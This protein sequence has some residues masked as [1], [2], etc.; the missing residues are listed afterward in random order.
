MK[1]YLHIIALLLLSSFAVAQQLP[2]YT[3]ANTNYYM[4]N[5][6]VAGTKKLIDARICYRTQWVGFEGAPVTQAFTLHSR[7]FKGMMGAGLIMYK[8]ETGPLK[9]LNYGASYAFHARF[10]DVELSLGA[11]GNMMKYTLTGADVTTHTSGDMAIDRTIEDSDW[12]PDL[13]FGALLYNDRFHFGISMLNMVEG[14]AQF[15][16]EDSLKEGAVTTRGHTF[17]SLGYNFSVGPDFVWE[18]TV[19]AGSVT[20]AP[21]L[22]D[23]NLRIHVREQFYGGFAF[24]VK[25]AVAFQAGYTFKKILQIG[26]SYDL[27][28]SRLRPYQSGSHEITLSVKTN[29]I[30]DK[31]KGKLD[32][33]VRQKYDLF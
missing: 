11:T 22:I 1:R 7:F 8:D 15:Y 6:A 18:H 16:E 2:Y 21:L 28:V 9:H 19:Q 25:D 17:L 24:R 3:Q 26:Y 12:V 23:Y 29:I 32:E 10:P 27:L 31:R 20:G 4:L 14:T 30:D 13:S 33:F 5:P